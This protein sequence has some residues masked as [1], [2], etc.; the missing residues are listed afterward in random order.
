MIP[1][2]DKPP[3]AESILAS[4]K[5][6]MNQPRVRIAMILLAV[7]TA[8]GCAGYWIKVLKP[9]RVIAETRFQS[10]VALM[11]LYELQIAYRGKHETFAKNLDDL[12]E[13]APDAMALRASLKANTDINTLAI[14]GDADRFRLEANILDPAR[15]AVKF[16]GTAVPR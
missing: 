7:M 5:R 6:W 8:F 12:L 9:M 2:M 13:G 10:H 16:R 1:I 11:R 15:T 14:I 3:P 4:Y